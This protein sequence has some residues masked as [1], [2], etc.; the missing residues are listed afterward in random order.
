VKPRPYTNSARAMATENPAKRFKADT[1][2]IG[3]HK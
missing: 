1:V 2:V 3:T